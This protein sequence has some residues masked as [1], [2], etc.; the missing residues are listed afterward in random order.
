MARLYHIVRGH[1]HKNS[2]LLFYLKGL[3]RDVWPHALCRMSLRNKLK[4]V[5][6]MNDEERE[7]I[8]RRVN[9]YCHLDAPIV[10]AENAY[11]LSR[12]TMKRKDREVT[13]GVHSAHYF[14][15]QEYARYFPKHLKWSMFSGDVNY[16]FPQPCI[17]KSRPIL[18]PE[19]PNNNILLKLNKVRHFLWIKDPFR[20]E[21]KEG[22]ILFR[23]D[24]QH[25]PH[26]ERF[27][28]MWH[29][30]PMCDVR[31]GG[32]LSLYD[33]LKY[34]Y[35]MS[36]EGNDVASNLKWVM[37][38]GSVA[39]MPRPKYETWFMESQLQP[40]F[41]YIEIRDDYSDLIDKINYYEAHPKEAKAIVQNAHEW[42]R[43][44]R[45]KRREDL[46]ALLVLEKYF[47]GTGQL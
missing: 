37:S 1:I 34:R 38:S 7:Y 28:G 13:G 8:M 25:K 11:P 17:C 27:V 5:E 35:I 12:F 19:E 21:E 4:A 9:H 33:H 2:H 45:N 18:P 14:D 39:V 32:G 16:C 15:C 46:I 30:H 29:D 43:Q 31:E 3:W 24:V 26:R 6:R 10:L 41:H 44:F 40:D 23:G 36:L 20:W 22:R 47:K 42:V